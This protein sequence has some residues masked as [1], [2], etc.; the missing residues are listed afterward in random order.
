M[1]KA[2]DEVRT[3]KIHKEIIE[4]YYNRLLWG[5]LKE[6]TEKQVLFSSIDYVIKND[7][8]LKR[9]SYLTSMLERAKSDD[10]VLEQLCVSIMLMWADFE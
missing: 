9:Y 6:K 8:K 5:N 10:K 4:E 1:I 7:V 2:F 3:I